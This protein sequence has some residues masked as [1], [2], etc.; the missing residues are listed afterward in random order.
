L[1]AVAACVINPYHV[2]VFQLP[3]E[4]AAWSLPVELR[5]DRYFEPFFRVPFARSY[6]EP[7]GG[8]APA[9]GIAQAF[10]YYLLFGLGLGSFAVNAGGWR[11][12]LALA[13][14]GFAWLSTLSHRLVPYFAVVAG[15]VLVLNLQAIAARRAPG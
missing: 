5:A 10:A 12:G 11:W 8:S 6:Y 14:L 7:V 3:N 2:H 15:P 9:A 4:F 1:V 13:W